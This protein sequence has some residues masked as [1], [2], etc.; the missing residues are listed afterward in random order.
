MAK[1]ARRYWD[2]S[3]FLAWLKPEPERFDICREVIRAAEKGEVQIVTST[4]SLTEV[5]KLNKGPI[6]LPVSVEKTI[7][8]FFKQEYIVLVQLTRFI[9]ES[10]R[11]LIWSY[12]SLRPKDAIHAATAL[13]AGIVDLDTFDKDFL[14]LDGQIGAQHMKISEP[15]MPQRE[16]PLEV[17]PEIDT[18]E[19]ELDNS[20]IH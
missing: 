18:D 16:L 10:A 5:I 9:A 2:S 7:S 1:T 20:E 17:P 8:D 3:C 15:H 19:D 11:S 13:Y 14:P 6:V 12:P 4:I